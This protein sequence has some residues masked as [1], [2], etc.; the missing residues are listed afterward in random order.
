M[1]QDRLEQ[2]LS[3][4]SLPEWSGIRDVFGTVLQMRS[5]A[6]E[7]DCAWFDMLADR[8]PILEQINSL[9]SSYAQ[10]VSAVDAR[11][12]AESDLMGPAMKL[13]YSGFQNCL[14]DFYA[15]VAA[16]PELSKLGY[17]EFRAK[18]ASSAG[19]AYDYDARFE[20]RVVCIEVK[21]L[22]PPRTVV[23]VFFE[24]VRRL[25]TSDAEHYPFNLAIEYFYDNTVTP[26][27]EDHIL[28]YLAGLCGRAAPFTDDVLFP[29]GTVARVKARPGQCTAMRL[30]ARGFDDPETFRV[31]GLLNKVKEKAERA[32]AQM[33]ATDGLKVLVLNINT[34]W[35]EIALSH[36]HAARN[37]VGQ[38]SDTLRPYFM[39]YYS[40]IPLDD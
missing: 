39:L 29:D 32:Q 11:R 24:E 2:A 17:H 26:E 19:K 7:A 8:L 23:D 22:R 12:K 6:M 40:L 16:V 35:A 3:N 21:H 27:Q 20:Q 37:V 30:T 18:H 4:L 1:N 10:L 28:R 36:L 13:P 34:P 31:E 5:T 14:G 9:C 33:S 38:V 15:E 25:G